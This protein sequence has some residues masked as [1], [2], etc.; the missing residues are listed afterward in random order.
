[1]KKWMALILF[2]FVSTILCAE[3]IEERHTLKELKEDF[4]IIRKDTKKAMP[5]LSNQKTKKAYLVLDVSKQDG[6]FLTLQATEGLA[7]YLNNK[8][9]FKAEDSEIVHLPFKRFEE[10]SKGESVFVFHSPNSNLDLDKFSLTKIVEKDFEEQF[11]LKDRIYKGRSVITFFLLLIVGMI[12]II[13]NTNA[14]IW[15]GYFDIRR[16]FFEKLNKAEYVPKNVFSQESIILLSLISILGGSLFYLYGLD[17]SLLKVN[18]TLS[19]V[20]YVLIVLAFL[21][22]KYFVLRIVTWFLNITPFGNRQFYDFLRFLLWYMF[23]LL[24]LTL[25]FGSEYGFIIKSFF[26]AGIVFW[27]IKIFMG[28]LERLKFQKLYLFSY[29]CASELMPALVL[30]NFIDTIH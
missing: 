10:L 12:A 8:L 19:F 25:T 7:I 2:V 29:I 30:V 13:K 16:V 15:S 23:G 9:V 20:Y 6:H 1:M 4:F 22:A 26:W 28:A 11:L 21:L 14:T 27:N 5:L 24:V 18:T 17:L 3:K